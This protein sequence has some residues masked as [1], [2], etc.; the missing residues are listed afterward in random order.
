MTRSEFQQMAEVRIEEAGVLL[1]AGKWDGAYYL[2][3]YAVECGLKA[4]VAKL[5]RA[6]EYPPREVKDYYTH[7]L[8]RLCKTAK[9]E[10][11]LK[12]ER[13]ANTAFEGYWTTAVVWD[14]QS[15]YNRISQLDAERLY[16]AI[17]DPTNGVLQWLRGHW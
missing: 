6:E 15:R 17:T 10:R 9:L 3:G 11:L 1:A 2:A 16:H 8:E 12:T 4:C 5:S 13:V 7:D 14:E